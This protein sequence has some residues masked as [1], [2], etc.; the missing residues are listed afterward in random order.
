MAD[1][2]LVDGDP[3]ADTSYIRRVVTVVTDGRISDSVAIHRALG[4]EPR[5]GQ[6]LPEAHLVMRRDRFESTADHLPRLA[7]PAAG[8]SEGTP[9]AGEGGSSSNESTER[10]DRPLVF[11]TVPV[12]GVIAGI[13]FA[14]FAASA[15]EPV[16]P[17]PTFEPA[18]CPFDISSLEVGDVRCGYVA[19]PENRAEANGRVIRL[20]VA[21]A[22]PV[23]SNAPRPP[24]A[25]LPGGPGMTVLSQGR[26][27]RLLRGWVGDR[28]VVVFDI[29]G[30]GETGPLMCPAL[31]VTERDIA[32]MDFPLEE[33]EMLER[34]A[35]LACRDELLSQGI[36]PAAYHSISIAEDVRDIRQALGYAEWDLFG[37]SY[38]S[39]LARNV[40][41]EDPRGTRSATVMAGPPPDPTQLLTRDIPFFHRALKHI[42][43]L[44]EADPLC[45]SRYPRLE[46]TFY[47]THQR[48][49]REPWTV[50]VSPAL[51]RR[52]QFTINGQDFIR[53]MYSLLGDR[54]FMHLPAV[55][56][57][58]HDGNGDVARAVV[59]RQ[60]GG[61]SSTFSTGMMYSVL[62]YDAHTPESRADWE[63]AAAPYPAPLSEIR[64]FLAPCED[65][66]PAR[67]SAETRA[68]IRSPIPTL[69]ITAER[70]AMGPAEIGE[71]ID[72]SLPNSFHVV[73]PGAAHDAA[74]GATYRPC[75]QELV[76]EFLG[77]PSKQP[78]AQCLDALPDRTISADLPGWVRDD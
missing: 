78:E 72:R 31:S 3:I 65:L 46:Q 42:F 75:L 61:L 32:A 74:F 39:W 69:I 68:L 33:A 23:S 9:R 76:T 1:L 36:D 37:G 73:L 14:S 10:V 35:Y 28:T 24:V 50:S 60:Y 4:I 54:D 57:A 67:A 21:V 6:K 48:L 30:T 47:E 8:V 51:F 13:A 15:Q 55:V 20:A 59:E 71:E 66:H 2:I 43:A 5:D 56:A 53:V 45:A 12:L 70:D 25:L 26:G 63:R 77:N 34:G 16:R 64:Y 7:Y 18:E 44:C 29:R 17:H 62:C 22:E 41:R 52:D 38:G 58:F 27:I 40:M 49:E 11:R 19:V